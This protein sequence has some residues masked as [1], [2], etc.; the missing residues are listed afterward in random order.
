M[1]FLKK[2]YFLCDD[3]NKD[4]VSCDIQIGFTSHTYHKIIFI[5]LSLLGILLSIIIFIDFIKEKIEK[6]QNKNLGSM[7]KI[8]RVLPVL[9]FLSSVYWLASSTLFIKVENINDNREMASI[10]SFLYI[11][12]LTFTLTYINCMLAHFR[13]MNYAPIESI[14]KANKSFL[15]YILRCL[16]ISV[17]VGLLALFLGVL[18]K[19]P[20]NTCFINSE[21][22]RKSGFI[23]LIIF[24]LIILSIYKIIHGLYFSKMFINK[25]KE[26]ELYIQN[27]LYA[28]IYSSLHIPLLLLFLV[29]FFRQKNIVLKDDFLPEFSYFCTILLYF[30]PLINS[31]M[32]I[33]QGMIKLKCFENIMKPQAR[34]NLNNIL[35]ND[36]TISLAVF[37]Q[38]DWLDKHAIEF[39]M[40]N[41]LLGI[42]ISIKRSK[43]IEIK[44]NK[45]DKNDF[46]DSTK[47]EI[48]FTNFDL[49]DDETKNSEYLDIK[50]IEYAPKCFKYLR[51]LEKIDIDEMIN[52]FLP[53][54]NKAG[55][56]KSA[57]KSGSFFISTDNNEYMIKTL[58]SDEFELIRNSFLAKY[59][60]YITDH[61]NSLLCRIYGIY[62]LIQYNGNDFY[63]IVMRNVIG[64]LKDSIVAKFDLK[65]S[66]TN[67]EVKGLNMTKIGGD[68]MKD[69]NF[70]DIEFGIMV[71][72]KNIEKIRNITTKDS[73][74]LEKL[75]LMDYSLFVV[76][77]SLDKQRLTDIFGEGIQE[78]QEKDYM[79]VINEKTVMEGNLNEMSSNLD[80]SLFKEK[81]E[82]T[83]TNSQY[84]HYKIY[85]F[86]GLN[87]RTA[88][89]IS[90]IDFLQSYNFYKFVE[91]ECK[92]T[93]GMSR[94]TDI[95]G[96]ISC[97]NPKLYS[98]RFINY[99]NNLTQVK[100]ILTDRMSN[101]ENNNENKKEQ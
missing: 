30:S 50:I 32:S 39:F 9:D 80:L 62:N 76:K 53:K 13:K 43:D 99:V 98:E 77:L 40:R 27:S 73:K 25:D 85:L 47:H 90:I 3:Y 93:F 69:L 70:N 34:Q 44:N 67:R 21:Q 83:N 23:Y 37:D 61:P 71:N 15:H 56:K 94:K 48:N 58:K 46:V 36:L 60:E 1:G 79:D 5:V 96:G 2:E 54:N 19:S 28:L 35:N 65:G 63:I 86:P 45:F 87:T 7:K 11:I 52:C 38:Y 72:N 74:F 17:C 95:H 82:I 89:I 92:T 84:K 6:H 20:M 29:T 10:L 81:Q 18:G 33:Y 8:F 97:V 26:R 88:Y 66:T 4:I 49:N 64:S 14:I 42:A 57:G 24:F 68:V 75:G 101:R 12:L 16:A 59:I 22:T 51:D 91:Y 31:A 55:M 78:K 41:I 100:Y